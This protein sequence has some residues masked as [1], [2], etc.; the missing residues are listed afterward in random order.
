MGTCLRLWGP[1]AGCLLTIRFL[2]RLP[3]WDDYKANAPTDCVLILTSVCLS[4][5]GGR[6]EPAA[7]T[8]FCL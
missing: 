4:K 5:K 2:A 7:L 6:L 1:D 8:D 3:L